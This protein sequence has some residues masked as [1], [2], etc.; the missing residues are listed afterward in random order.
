MNLL[1]AEDLHTQLMSSG[2]AAAFVKLV[3]SNDNYLKNICSLAFCNLS[4]SE[5][6]RTEIMKKK[7]I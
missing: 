5:V 3:D 4:Y 2:A 7:Y 1:C 6:G